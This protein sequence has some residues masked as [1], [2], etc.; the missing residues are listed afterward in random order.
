MK[1]LGI[2]GKLTVVAQRNKLQVKEPAVVGPH[3]A[4]ADGVSPAQ[5]A[6]QTGL[7]PVILV[8]HLDGRVRRRR[9]PKLL[10]LGDVRPQRGF[11]LLGRRRRLAR[12]LEADA[13]RVAV[14][15]GDAVARGRDAKG[16]L[17]DEGRAGVVD[18][19]E[20]LPRLRLEL[21]LLA[22]NE[23][24]DVVHDVHAGDARVSGAG[25]GLHGDDADF[26]DGTKGGLQGGEGD[27][28]ADDGAVG[29]ADEEALGQA[30]DGALVRDQVEVRQVDGRDDERD[31]GVAAVIFGVGEDGDFGLEE[32]HFCHCDTL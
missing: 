9:A 16:L 2:K 23:G 31:E 5:V 20:N 6:I 15:D 19:A 11:A 13:G 26:G 17:L 4:H 22:R 7:R 28:E 24:H 32:G 12:K 30:V 14:H 21:V 29:V 25:N 8:K 18:A 3:P 10:R 27:D 1:K